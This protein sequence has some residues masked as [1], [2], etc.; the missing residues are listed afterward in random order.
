V[1]GDGVP[2]VV[3]AGISCHDFEAL[4]EHVNDFAFALVAPLRADDNRCLANFQNATP[5]WVERTFRSASRQPQNLA[6]GDEVETSSPE[7]H[8][9]F[10]LQ[11]RPEGLLY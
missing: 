4:G 8:L 1:N 7:A 6:S 9:W 3:A 2:G 11:R 10:S 5:L